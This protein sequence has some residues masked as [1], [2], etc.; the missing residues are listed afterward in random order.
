MGSLFSRLLLVAAITLG[1]A[2]G[3]PPDDVEKQLQ[4]MNRVRAEYVL[5][6]RN[7]D[8]DPPDNLADE[9]PTSPS[10]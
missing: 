10:S 5:R 8:D 7:S 6:Q 9:P 4:S 3:M 1:L 2:G